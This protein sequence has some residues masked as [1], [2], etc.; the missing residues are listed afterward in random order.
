VS[1]EVIEGVVK[2]VNGT[3][4]V[5]DIS[6]IPAFKSRV[7]SPIMTVDEAQEAW[8]QYQE[9][10]NTLLTDDDYIYFVQCKIK[11]RTQ[12]A[13]YMTK[14]D[15]DRGADTWKAMGYPVTLT[16]RKKK[17]AFRKMARFFGLSIPQQNDSAIITIEPLGNSHFVKTEKGE[18]YSVI[19]YM[20]EDMDTVKC[21]ASVSVMHPGGATMVGLGTC[22]ARERGFTHPDHDIIATSWTRA[23]NRAISDMV[24]WGEVSAEEIDAITESNTKPKAQ[25]EPDKGKSEESKSKVEESVDEKMGLATFLASAFK[26]GETAESLAESYGSLSEIEDYAAT[27]NSI[28]D[29]KETKA[30]AESSVG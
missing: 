13:T 18:G 11:D 29:G 28:K 30:S 17:S 27:L 9:L 21:E 23:L 7:V 25:G 8:A 15:A 12:S 26:L 2:E 5:Q 19:T 16:R 1:D 20:D 22:S 4:S 14:A 10:E 24:G 3:P 6:L